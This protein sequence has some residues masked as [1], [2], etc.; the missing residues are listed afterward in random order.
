M[1][2]IIFVLGIL[3]ASFINVSPVLAEGQYSI[4]HMTPEVQSALENRRGRFEQL[5]ALKA[6]GAIGENNHGYVDALGGGS[7]VQSLATAENSD[8]RVIYTTIGEQNGLTD[9][10]TTIESVFAQVQRDKAESGDKIQTE[11]G[12]WVSK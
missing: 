7:A 3:A 10:L 5:R 12:Q 11:D 4:K 9:A 1:Y 8:R 2:R 6:N